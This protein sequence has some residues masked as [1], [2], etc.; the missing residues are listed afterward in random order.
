[1]SDSEK[2]H[3]EGLVSVKG[4]SR[5]SK[6]YKKWKEEILKNQDTCQI[7]G[8]DKCLEVHH[9]FGFTKNPHYRINPDNGIVLC[10]WCHEKYHNY[11][12]G[13]ATPVSLI[14]FIKQFNRGVD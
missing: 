8:G 1:M 12:P 7:C 9:V 4:E 5:T 13:P 6:K 14:K 2:I 10:K 3:V 11:Y